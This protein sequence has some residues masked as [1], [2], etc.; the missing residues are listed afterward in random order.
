MNDPNWERA[1]SAYNKHY[2]PHAEICPE[3]G[4]EDSFEEC[5]DEGSFLKCMNCGYI[6]DE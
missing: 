1:E 6:Y 2:D 4:A 5:T 3:C